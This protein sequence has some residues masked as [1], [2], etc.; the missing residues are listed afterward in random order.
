[1]RTM[2]P[3]GTVMTAIH[4]QDE[5]NRTTQ[6][7]LSGT[8]SI[9]HSLS[10]LPFFL[11]CMGGNWEGHLSEWKEDCVELRL[12]GFP[13]VEIAQNVQLQYCVQGQEHALQQF[14]CVIQDIRVKSGPSVWDGTT[15]ILLQCGAWNGDSEIFPHGIGVFPR[16]GS[17]NF[18]FGK[19]VEASFDSSW[20]T[21]QPDHH[22]PVLRSP[23]QQSGIGFHDITDSTTKTS[24]QSTRL[25]IEK[26]NGQRISA[27]HDRPVADETTELPVVVISPGYGETKRDYLTLAYYFASNGFQVVR[28]DHTNHVGE[29]DGVHYHVSL[30]SMKDDFQ[31]VVRSVRARWPH[32]AMIGVASSLAARVALKAEAECPSLSL[33]IMLM[34][35]VNVQRSA[36]TVHQEDVFAGY[37]NGQYPESANILGFNVGSQFLA[38]ANTNKFVTLNH[39]LSEAESL[40]SSVIVVSAGKDAWVAF[41]DLQAF[42]QALGRRAAKWI[43]VPEALHRLQENPKIARETYRQLVA[44]CRERV[45]MNSTHGVIHHP[46][47]LDLG[48]QNRKEKIALQQQAMTEVGP[49]FW[50]DYLGKFQ[51]VGKCPDYVKLLDHV[52]HALGPITPGQQFLDAGCGNGNAGVYFLS[53]LQ[54]DIPAEISIA[55]GSIQYVGI[56]VVPEGLKRANRTMISA[57]SQR[58]QNHFSLQ[59]MVRMSWAQVDLGHPLPFPD[60]QFDR[61]VSNLVVG[62]VQNPGAALKELYRVLAPGGRMV[63]SNLKPNGDFSGIYQ[64]LVSSAALPQQREE[65]RDLLNNY[66]K[67]RQAEKEGQFCFFDRTEWESHVAGLGCTN[68]KVY[69]TFAGQA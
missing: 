44:E 13:P 16:I 10:P 40:T 63:I 18:L 14:R 23:V 49:C 9:L 64:S 58:Q 59:P 30:S 39:T 67:I 60:N 52:F 25:C 20:N 54:S 41:E 62:Y 2:A 8:L 48:R 42:R 12:T 33:L 35:I 47:R 7:L 11:S 55:N 21:E 38:D 69:P 43:V 26:I 61:I 28:Y 45:T 27:Y 32:S 65:A 22:H 4:D 37:R 68:G 5:L 1:M 36:A 29:S 19:V 51:A 46:N 24:I 17:G 6:H 50:Q 57:I 56:D 15:D 34:G 31:T 53:R 3:P 66:G